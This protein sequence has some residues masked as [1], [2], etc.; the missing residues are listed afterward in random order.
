VIGFRFSRRLT[1]GPA[2]SVADRR[3]LLRLGMLTM[4]RSAYVLVRCAVDALWS[5][6]TARYTAR[7]D[8]CAR[9]LDSILPTSSA[10]A[11]L[12]DQGKR[13]RGQSDRE[14]EHGEGACRPR[15]L[16]SPWSMPPAPYQVKRG[17][18]QPDRHDENGQGASCPRRS[19]WLRPVPPAQRKLPQAQ[20]PAVSH[21]IFSARQPAPL[22][23]GCNPKR[24]D[25]RM[26]DLRPFCRQSTASSH[27]RI[28]FRQR[29]LA[30]LEAGEPPG[31]APGHVRRRARAD[32]P[33][34]RQPGRPRRSGLRAG[35]RAIARRGS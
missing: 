9:K 24:S 4:T 35:C 3:H 15:A 25:A 17:R 5:R 28:P 33:P 31:R 22:R 16:W 23:T 30:L 21:R 7:S 27:R 13:D 1:Q 32:R 12:A 11:S 20:V 34:P 2:V 18:G 29:R 19:S 14:H 6:Q 10:L 8:S 26:T